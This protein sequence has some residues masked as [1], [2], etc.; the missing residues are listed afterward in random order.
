LNLINKKKIIER[1]LEIFVVNGIAESSMKQ[2][3]EANN[4]DRRTLYRYFGSKEE[5]V[6]EV[7]INVLKEWNE[8][9]ST[10]FNSLKGTGIQK[11]KDFYSILLRNDD[12]DNLINLITEFDTIF[13]LDDF[14]EK[15]NHIKCVDD[16]YEEARF[17]V[18]ILKQILKEGIDD[19]TIVDI[20]IDETAQV[21]HN[22]I[23]GVVQKGASSSKSIN[24]KLKIDF[25]TITYKQL[26]MYVDLLGGKRCLS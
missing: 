26:D 19:G 12:K 21:I 3:A 10:T 18:E 7:I 16:Y 5:I 14:D 20:D 2:I 6:L 24:D 13:S 22:V 11:F 25:R 1:A 17:P 9:Q 15:E 4:Y 8:F 23:W